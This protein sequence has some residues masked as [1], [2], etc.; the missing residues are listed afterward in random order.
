MTWA[1][2]LLG[3]LGAISGS[4][5]DVLCVKAVKFPQHAWW[6]VVLAAL[7]FSTSAPIWYAMS[8]LS[9]GQYVRPAIVWTLASTITVIAAVTICD[10]HQ[11]PRQWAGFALILIGALVRG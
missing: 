8:R 10:G 9:G 5:A 1:L 4:G 7:M 2:L 3:L 6:M 11:S